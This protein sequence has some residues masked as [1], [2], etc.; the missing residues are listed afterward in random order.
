MKFTCTKSEET[1]KKKSIF[2]IREEKIN[3]DRK[4][5]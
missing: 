4:K 1:I 2:N 3:T 5:N